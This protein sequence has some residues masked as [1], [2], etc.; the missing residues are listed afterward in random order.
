MGFDFHDG[1]MKNFFSYYDNATSDISKVTDLS[2]NRFY[3]MYLKNGYYKVWYDN[4]KLNHSTAK[5]Y[6]LSEVRKNAK[7]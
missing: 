5:R 1:S 2:E 7:K 4:T 6:I 3:V